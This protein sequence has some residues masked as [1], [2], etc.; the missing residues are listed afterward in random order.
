MGIKINSALL[1]LSAAIF[2]PASVAQKNE[3]LK[4]SLENFTLSYCLAQSGLG[5]E[6]QQEAK[7]AVGAYVE[8]GAYTAEAYDEA[9]DVVKKYLDK[10]YFSKKQNINLTVMKCIDASQSSEI[11]EIKK[12]YPAD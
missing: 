12:R 2:S 6:L 11:T 7:A 10:T 5:D 9:T 3:P 8:R 1:L 4:N